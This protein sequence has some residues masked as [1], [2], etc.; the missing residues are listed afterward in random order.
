[1]R[2]D[3]QT[4]RHTILEHHRFAVRELASEVTTQSRARDDNGI[5]AGWQATQLEVSERIRSCAPLR[6]G[7][8][9]RRNLTADLG[10]YEGATGQRVP[11]LSNDPR[12]SV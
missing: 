10:F 11:E 12:H 7:M 4:T 6:P 1:M 9:A 8:L 5:R 3:I 2:P